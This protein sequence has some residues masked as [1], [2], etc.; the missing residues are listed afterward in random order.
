MKRFG[1]YK[2]QNGKG[3]Q[4]K[5]FGDM[6]NRI[7]ISIDILTPN[8]AILTRRYYLFH[9]VYI[10]IN[11]LVIAH[12]YD[13]IPDQFPIHYTMN[14][15]I[16]R[17]ASKSIP[18]VF[19]LNMVQLGYLVIM[20]SIMESIYRNERLMGGVSSTDSAK[21]DIRRKYIL[22]VHTITWIGFV[23][24]SVTQL[25]IIRFITSNIGWVLVVA[26]VLILAIGIIFGK[27]KEHFSGK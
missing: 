12:F 7:G 13:Q 2:T 8:R 6:C 25:G 3:K 21:P 19:S 23:L 20:V 15:E 16:D 5:L 18:F 27:S 9:L 26:S 1:K 22:I 24:F 4:M 14:G 11:V 17:V 10:V